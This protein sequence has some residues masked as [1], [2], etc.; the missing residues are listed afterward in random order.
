MAASGSIKQAA[1]DLGK[2][3]RSVWGRI[4]A[5]E[6]TLGCRLVEAHVGGQGTQRSFLTDEARQLVHAFLALRAR[7][8]QLVEEEAGR[9]SFL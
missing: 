2:S 7:I 8:S 5:A 1:R 9:V 6:E 4:K 3:Y